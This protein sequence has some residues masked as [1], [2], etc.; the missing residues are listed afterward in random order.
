MAEFEQNVMRSLGTIEGQLTTLVP[1]VEQQ[2][3]DHGELETR[4]RVLENW[5][6]YLVGGITLLGAI[7][8]FMF[9]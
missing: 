4:T 5:R 2:R 9:K 3:E 1:M 7:V 8:G 6:W